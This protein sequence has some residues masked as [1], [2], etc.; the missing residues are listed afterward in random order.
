MKDTNLKDRKKDHID[1]AFDSQIDH[2]RLDNRFFYEPLFSSH[3]SDR[4]AFEFTLAGKDLK[5]PFW[6]SSMTGGTEKA[7]MINRNLAKACAKYQMGMGLGSCRILLDTPESLP[8]FDLRPIL[9]DKVPFFA[10]IGIAQLEDALNKNHMDRW[11]ELIHR[12]TA[13]GLIVHINPLQEWMQPE[14]DRITAPPVETI[15]RLLDEFPLPVIVKEV[16]QGM[17]KAS[18]DALLRLPL[19][20]IDFAANGGT[21][22]TL[23][24]LLRSDAAKKD[25]FEGLTRIGHSAEEMVGLSNDLLKQNKDK[26]LTKNLIISGGVKGFLDGYYLHEKSL[27][28]AL[29][30]QASALLKRALVSFEDLDEYLDNQHRGWALCQ[31]YLALKNEVK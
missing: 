7:G 24:E 5:S 30:G 23:V 25:V 2:R 26:Y 13:D 1:L 6:V 18:L 11:L 8:D 19:E 27:F 22:F 29:I 15:S 17:G 12:L 20:A 3:P 14:G 28:P 21:N 4:P 10:N 31:N 9:G 16:G